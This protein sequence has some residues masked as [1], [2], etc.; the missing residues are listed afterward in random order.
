[1]HNATYLYDILGRRL[2]VTPGERD[3][4][5]RGAIAHDRPVRTFCSLLY[6][7]GYGIAEA[8]HVIPRRVDFA[9]QVII[10][11]RLKR[12]RNFKRLFRQAEEY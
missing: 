4:F 6:Y 10:I 1:M 3:A 2:Y 11:E 8:L 12:Y 5:L 7:T 9:D